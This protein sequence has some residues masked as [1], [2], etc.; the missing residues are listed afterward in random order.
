MT[1]QLAD[2]YG[3]GSFITEFCA[4]G[5]KNY[6]YVVAVKG[7]LNELKMCVKVRGI[8]INKSCDEL[9]T[10]T[11]LKKMVLGEQDKINI[12]I[13]RQIARLPTWKV[14]TRATSKNWQAVN[15]KRRR[16]DRDNTVP[17]GYTAWE[18]DKDDQE[19]LEAMDT[20]ME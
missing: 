7:N 10:Y 8:T 9:V 2:D 16:V 19:L 1:D 3:P 15:T 14:V 20:L 11:N 13:P 17:Y 18:G 6:G 5:P 12:P 4:A